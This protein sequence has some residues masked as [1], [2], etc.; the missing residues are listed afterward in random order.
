MLFGLEILLGSTI[1][2]F[3][4]IGLAVVFLSF[5]C[6]WLRLYDLDRFAIDLVVVDSFSPAI[7]FGIVIV[8]SL[9][10]YFGIMFTDGP[11]KFREDNLTNLDLTIPCLAKNTSATIPDGLG[12]HFEITTALVFTTVWNSTWLSF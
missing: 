11:T 9:A 2:S 10:S 4:G 7:P 5:F 3:P 8:E 12:I 1:F 6:K